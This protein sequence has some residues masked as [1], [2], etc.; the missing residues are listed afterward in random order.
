[1]EINECNRS[2]I[3]ENSKLLRILCFKFEDTTYF[4]LDKRGQG[5]PKIRKGKLN[6]PF[7]KIKQKKK[8][9]KL[10]TKLLNISNSLILF[11]NC[12]LFFIYN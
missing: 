7:L 12:S 10:T 1:M 2:P 6:F 3:W 5:E 11:Q 8:L 9:L 4:A